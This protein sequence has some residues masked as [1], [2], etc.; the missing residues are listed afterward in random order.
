M[1]NWYE[2]KEGECLLCC[3]FGSVPVLSM[4]SFIGSKIIFFE[5]LYACGCK[6]QKFYPFTEE[7]TIIDDKGK[8]KK[9]KQKINGLILHSVFTDTQFPFTEEIA[10]YVKD[11]RGFACDYSEIYQLY[12]YNCYKN[13]KIINDISILENYCKNLHT[14]KLKF[15]KIIISNIIKTREEKEVEF[16]GWTTNWII[17]I[18]FSRR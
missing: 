10:K 12:A 1:P 6:H 18:W 8:K 16:Y 5:H 9:I 4:K 13:N 7:K 17:W 2:N 11:K 3:N 14:E 15:P